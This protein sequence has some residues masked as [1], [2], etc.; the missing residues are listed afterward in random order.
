MEPGRLH[1][2]WDS[3]VGGRE[4]SR[5]RR[6]FHWVPGR[7]S[8]QGFGPPPRSY[9]APCQ[10]PPV[11]VVS[12]SPPSEVSP[13]PPPGPVA[14]TAPVTPDGGT[15]LWY[16]GVS[17]LISNAFRAEL[18]VSWG[19]IPPGGALVGTVR[20]LGSLLDRLQVALESVEEGRSILLQ[21]CTEVTQAMN[22][23]EKA[24]HRSSAVYATTLAWPP[25]TG[26]GTPY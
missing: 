1:H 4:T 10:A 22:L 15:R 6:E 25:S 16:K 19:A 20:C 26:G 24:A 9:H 14:P 8:S 12:L 5:R 18:P 11:P 13:A 3:T 17:A 7:R 21:L 23:R 2:E